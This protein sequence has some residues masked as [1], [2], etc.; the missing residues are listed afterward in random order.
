MTDHC[1]YVDV[2]EA[3]MT[4]REQLARA[5]YLSI[6]DAR[7]F[8]GNGSIPWDAE[9]PDDWARGEAFKAID[10]ILST[11]MNPTPEMIEDGAETPGMKAIDACM[12]MHQA[13]GY[14]FAEGAFD[15]GSPLLQAWQAMLRRAAKGEG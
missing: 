5:A 1:G 14:G 12:G 6:A 15:E 4:M 13:R 7:D 8:Y 9:E 10:A 3:S 2:P 11:L